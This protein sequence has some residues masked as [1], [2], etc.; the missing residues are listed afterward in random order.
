VRRRWDSDES[1]P[2]KL[3]RKANLES[4]GGK[5]GMGVQKFASVREVREGGKCETFMLSHLIVT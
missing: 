2:L 1:G 3:F 4:E 5:V